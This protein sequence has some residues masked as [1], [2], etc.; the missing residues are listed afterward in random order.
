MDNRLQIV[1][2]V[3]LRSMPIFRGS[4]LE[5]VLELADSIA[6]SANSSTNF[7]V[8]GQLSILNMLNVYL[9]IQS[10]DGN[11][12]KMAVCKKRPSRYWPFPSFLYTV[13]VEISTQY[14]FL[15]FRISCRVLYAQKI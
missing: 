15:H 6:K 3:M 10:A 2:C 9:L 4:S 14:I 1:A 8:L 11:H 7:V 13:N 5:S 12:P